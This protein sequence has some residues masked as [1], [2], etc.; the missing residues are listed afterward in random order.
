MLVIDLFKSEHLIYPVMVCDSD[1]ITNILNIY[2]KLIKE[3]EPLSKTR[4]TTNKL[5]S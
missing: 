2:N 1:G 3:K 4:T 5:N